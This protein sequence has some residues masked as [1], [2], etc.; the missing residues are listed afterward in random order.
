MDLIIANVLNFVL[1]WNILAV[2][3]LIFLF[4]SCV[5]TV[6]GKTAAIVE[7]FGKPSKAARMP[8]LQL[9]WPWPIQAVVEYVELQQ[10]EVKEDVTVKTK[11]NAFMTLPVTVQYRA[12]NDAEGAVKAHYELDNPEQQISSYILNNVRQTAAS[13]DMSDLFANRNSMES[14]VHSALTKQF[15]GFGY[16][17][18]NVLVDE[19]QPSKEVR[20][21]FNHVIASKQLKA[22]AQNEADAAQINL[23]GVATAEAESKKL[24]GEGMANMREAIA[25]GLKDALEIMQE[26]GLTPKQAMEFLMDTNR[27]DTISTAAAHGNTILIDMEKQSTLSETIAAVEA[28]KATEKNHDDSVVSTVDVSK[29]QSDQAA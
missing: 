18:V 11:D 20:N 7:T 9:K 29:E 10:Q 22:A 5:F 13:M 24:Q 19:P 8:G 27:L 6:S 15:H 2:L 14:E 26:A 17:I 12:R 23:V 3:V 1:S 25:R 28:T 21:A 4:L 16:E